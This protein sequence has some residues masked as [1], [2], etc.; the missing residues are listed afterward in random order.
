MKTEKV[1]L[2]GGP[3]CGEVVDWPEEAVYLKLQFR[4]QTYIYMREDK[5]KATLVPQEPQGV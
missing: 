3:R 1:E 2:V 4:G 5:T